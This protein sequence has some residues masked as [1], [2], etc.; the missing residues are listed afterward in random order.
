MFGSARVC[1]AGAG[2]RLHKREV[3]PL[4]QKTSKQRSRFL[5]HMYQKHRTLMSLRWLYEEHVVKRRM[6]VS[7]ASPSF[8]IGCT[9]REPFQI[10]PPA[11]V[12]LPRVS[13]L[14]MTVN[15]DPDADPIKAAEQVL[16]SQGGSVA[17]NEL[18][19]FIEEQTANGKILCFYRC[20]E[21]QVTGGEDKLLIRAHP[22]FN[23]GPWYDWVRVSCRC[24]VGGSIVMKYYAYRVLAIVEV[25][26]RDKNKVY[27]FAE[28]YISSDAE[29]VRDLSHRVG[30]IELPCVVPEVNAGEKFAL[31]ALNR[32]ASGL[33]TN[34]SYVKEKH[35]WVLTY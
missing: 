24:E 22:D 8:L 18:S 6:R 19:A 12:Q 25:W 21:M 4:F 29:A 23:G 31:L 26:S 1:D 5:D 33:W 20:L 9:S 17:L 13:S 11:A 32:I 35:H 34:P 28:K 7:A 30:G 10:E 3:K 15:N 27:V 14:C 2:E 16:K